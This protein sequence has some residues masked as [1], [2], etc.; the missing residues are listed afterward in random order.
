MRIYAREG[1]AW[2]WLVEPLLHTVEVYELRD[3]AWV[4]TTV[5]GSDAPARLAPFDAVELDVTQWWLESASVE[6]ISR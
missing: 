5:H 2:L 3:G 1:V 6:P 4:V